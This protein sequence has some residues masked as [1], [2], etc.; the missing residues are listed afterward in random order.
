MHGEEREGD[1]RPDN[2]TFEI[3]AKS[4]MYHALASKPLYTDAI[5]S[6]V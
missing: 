1:E 3:G 5:P 2:L 4:E 6:S